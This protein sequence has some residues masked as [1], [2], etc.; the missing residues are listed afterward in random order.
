MKIGIYRIVGNE[1]PPRDLPG[2]RVRTTQYIS[3]QLHFQEGVTQHWV[4]NRILDLRLQQQLLQTLQ[5]TACVVSVLPADPKAVNTAT[6]FHEK[7]LRAIDINKARNWA[8]D[9]GQ[10]RGYDWTVILDGDCHFTPED[11]Q[12]F[13]AVAESTDR[14]TIGIPSQ[15]CLVQHGQEPQPVAPLGEPMLAFNSKT[16]LR[17]DTTIPF[18]E[19]DKLRLLIQLGFAPEFGKNAELRDTTNCVLGGKVQHLCLDAAS[20][21]Q[22]EDTLHRV[23]ARNA[24]LKQLISRYESPYPRDTLASYNTAWSSL[25]GFFDFQGP[26]SG[27]ADD[28]KDGQPI[29]EVGAWLGKSAVYLAEELRLRGKTNVIYCVDTWEGDDSLIEEVARVGGPEKLFQAFLK[30]TAPY[31]GTIVPVRMASEQAAKLFRFNSLAA[32]FLDGAHDYDSVCT[33]LHQWYPRVQKGGLIAGHDYVPE[34]P[35]SKVGVVASVDTFFGSRCLERRPYS[36]VWKH[37][38]DYSQPRYWR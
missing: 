22:E 34:H 2:A 25:G 29:V 30:N 35:V 11:L 27:I 18:G 32:V 7:V 12:A 20:R 37:V 4:L 6:T 28:V 13:L 36:R 16:R 23:D 8:I 1:L 21:R 26:Y 31:R 17:F 38:K 3:Q 9:D 10:A 14:P 33:D 19:G 15:R 5:P 24:G